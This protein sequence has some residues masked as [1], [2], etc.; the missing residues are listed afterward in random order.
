MN[1]R[2]TWFTFVAVHAVPVLVG[3][4]LG[5]TAG[6]RCLFVVHLGLLAATFIPRI[7]VWGRSLR[8]FR[9]FEKEVCIS[10]DDG[11]TADTGEILSLFD[12]AGVRAIFFLIGR[13]V[14]ENPSLCAEIARRGHA[15]GNHTHTHPSAWFWGYGPESQ[16]KEIAACSRAISEAGGGET[17]I[18]RPPVGFRNLFNAP[19]LRELGMVNIGWSARG[20]DGTDNDVERILG[21]IMAALRPGAIILLHQGK[22]H[23]ATLLRRLLAELKDG[24]WKIV[25]PAE[26]AK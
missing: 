17:K 25:L 10:I 23:H 6:I 3:W 26:I 20:F 22:P 2:L 7:S 4:R 11:P 13:R 14:G 16:R 8:T 1:V 19:V 21:R 5:V 9:T 12:E 18:F 24:G 15:I